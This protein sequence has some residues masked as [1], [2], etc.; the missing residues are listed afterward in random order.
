MKAAKRSP[1]EQRHGSLFE[2]NVSA[3]R[4]PTS[5]TSKPWQHNSHRNW[6][7]QLK[8]ERAHFSLLPLPLASPLPLCKGSVCEEDEIESE[9]GRG[10]GKEKA[11]LYRVG[12]WKRH[13]MSH[14]KSF[15][16]FH[17]KQKG[18][19]RYSLSM[20]EHL[21]VCLAQERHLWVV[22]TCSASQDRLGLWC[23]FPRSYISCSSLLRCL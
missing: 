6:A 8:R 4:Q 20:L 17:V 7:Q 9:E 3:Q 11:V 10:R 21:M 2:I 23:G 16:F 22:E 14:N 5:F 1:I 12:N 13:G 15:F 19:A 18:S